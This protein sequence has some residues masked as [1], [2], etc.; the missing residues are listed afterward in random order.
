MASERYDVV[1][2]G[3]GPAGYIAAI[4]AA[5]LGMKVACAEKWINPK[6]EL[7]LGGSEVDV[8]W[9]HTDGQPRSVNYQVPN[10]NQCLNCHSQN[11]TF[12]PIGP[13]AQNMNRPHPDNSELT[14]QLVHLQQSGMLNGL[15]EVAAI[16]SL[17]RFDD[18]H[19][20]STETKARSWL[21]VNCAHCHSPGGTAR[22]SGLDLRWEQTDPAKLGVFKSP[23]AAGHGSGGRKYDI[24]P[25][26]PDESI[27]LFRLESQ[28]PAILMPN[29]GRKLVHTEAVA[30]VRDWI[31]G[32][33]ELDPP[34]AN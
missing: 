33:P 28:D 22:T 2:I 26:R 4:R 6:G 27:L 32:L 11:K 18:P 5:Q 24:V 20:G 30:V 12:V 21:D 15:P 31:Q 3:A 1:V 17:P 7:A 23:V 14:N 13:T 16:P 19:S 9:I 25:G 8:T 34:P 29:V 10:A